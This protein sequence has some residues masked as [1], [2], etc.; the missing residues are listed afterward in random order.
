[1]HTDRR[2]GRK[3]DISYVLMG[4]GQ[5]RADG[6]SGVS[7]V[8]LISCRG[9]VWKLNVPSQKFNCYSTSAHFEGPISTQWVD[10]VTMMQTLDRC[11]TH[12]FKVNSLG[13]ILSRLHLSKRALQGPLCVLSSLFLFFYLFVSGTTGSSH[14][15]NLAVTKAR[16]HPQ[17]L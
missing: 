6:Q 5:Q 9:N 17:C 7:V 15:Q 2:L 10:S 11:V 1:M 8:D 3:R 13:S 12:I 4:R 16:S 14:C